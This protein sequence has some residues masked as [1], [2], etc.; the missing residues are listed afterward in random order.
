MLPRML[1]YQRPW[2]GRPRRKMGAFM[3][4][5]K[6][7]KAIET[8]CGNHIRYAIGSMQGWRA[9][10]ED[11][12]VARIGLGN[13]NFAGWS[14]FAVF[15]GHAG[16]QVADYAAQ[17]I[18]STIL[19]CSEFHE[20]ASSARTVTEKND[21]MHL[22]FA[23]SFLTLDLQMRRLPGVASGEERS[24]STVICALIGPDTI[25]FS[26]LGDSRGIAVSNGNL[27]VVTED[28]KPYRTDEQKRIVTAGGSVT[29]QRI[30]GNLAV[31]RALGDYDYKN[32]LDRGP[33]EQLVS[34]EPD[35]YPLPRRNEDEFIVLACDGVWD[36]MGSEEFYR[37]VRY[38]LQVTSS[39]DHICSTILDVC[40]GR[41]SRDN[42]TVALIVFPGAPT[43]SEEVKMLDR[44]LDY[45]IE[46]AVTEIVAACP[47]PTVMDAASLV[48]L[49]AECLE[50]FKTKIPDGSGGARNKRMLIEK[51]WRQM[52]PDKPLRPDCGEVST[53]TVLKVMGNRNLASRFPFKSLVKNR[54]NFT[55][56]NK[57]NRFATKSSVERL[58]LTVEPKDSHVNDRKK[59]DAAE[60]S[61]RV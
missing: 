15:D 43:V 38:Q 40:L 16:K 44:Q 5:P 57:S 49:V 9:E 10:M 11:T 53:A 12:H 42:I 14:F 24:G 30:N 3:D 54:T 23:K 45:H 2:A 26:N 8:G 1:Y 31:S 41:G 51:L 13:S 34:P 27:M 6:T 28:H 18:L 36:V 20:A 39:L 56:A 55:E 25:Y 22:V 7:D 58:E 46:R 50:D 4:K 61:R 17:N 29:M 33:F 59:G 37:F 19:G 21:L 60:I 48:H 52:R 35:L 32:R 47:A